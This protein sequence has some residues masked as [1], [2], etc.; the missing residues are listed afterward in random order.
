MTSLMTDIIMLTDMVKGN[1]TNVLPIILTPYAIARN[2]TI[3]ISCIWVNATSSYFYAKWKVL[4]LTDCQWALDVKEELMAK[5]L[6][7][8]GMFKKEL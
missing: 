2:S 8:E 7:S 3:R 5:D 6:H 1:L 4:E